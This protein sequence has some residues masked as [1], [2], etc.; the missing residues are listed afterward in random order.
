MCNFCLQYVHR[1]F[2]PSIVTPFDSAFPCLV[3]R[4]DKRHGTTPKLCVS[5]T[6][7]RQAKVFSVVIS[8]CVL[9]SPFVML[10]SPFV[11][12]A[13]ARAAKTST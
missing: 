2:L 1:V 10:V 8:L 11:M 12:L 5:R 13:S 6:Y 9:L 3:R 7:V 4:G